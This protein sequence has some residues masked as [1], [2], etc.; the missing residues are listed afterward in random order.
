[1]GEA[2]VEV[3]SIR[4]DKTN[5]YNWDEVKDTDVDVYAKKLTNH[6]SQLASKY[7]PYKTITVRQSDPPWLTYTIKK[8]M[9]TRKRLNDKYKRTNNIVDF[10][11]FKQIRNNVTNEIR[12][13]KYI[14]TD[15][16]AQNLQMILL[17]LKTGGK[18]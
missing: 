12:K 16:L 15:R 9:R 2:E 10:E 3:Y 7:I 6:I 1:M 18:H 13:S 11:N 8:M 14:Q 17:D 4:K 5:I